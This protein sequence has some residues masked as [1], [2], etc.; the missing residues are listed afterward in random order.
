[1]RVFIT[2]SIIKPIEEDESSENFPQLT[3]AI[4]AF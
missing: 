4:Y 1:M 3:L 2:V